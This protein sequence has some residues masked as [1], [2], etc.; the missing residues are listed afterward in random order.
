MALPPPADAPA[1]TTA[2]LC[3]A[4]EDLQVLEHGLRDYGG[5]T[6]FHGEVRTLKLFED[7]SLVRRALEGPGHGRVLVVDGG[8]SLRC[9][10]LGDMLGELAVKNGWAGVVVHGAVRDAE[11]LGR[12]PLGVKALGT[13]PRKSHKRGEGQE[14]VPVRLLGVT[15]PPGWHLYADGDGVVVGPKALL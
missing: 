1:F 5:R 7:N 2:D 8:G 6:R 13:H 3:D 15:V 14:D 10:L 11:A 9:A 12:L 4:H